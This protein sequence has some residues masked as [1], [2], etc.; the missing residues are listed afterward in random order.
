MMNE[1]GV[2]ALKTQALN[3]KLEAKKQMEFFPTSDPAHET[4]TM[5]YA[6]SLAKINVIN[7]IL[8]NGKQRNRKTPKR[9]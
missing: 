6:A 7:K 8:N 5:V 4:A 3:E 2:A 1:K 9:A